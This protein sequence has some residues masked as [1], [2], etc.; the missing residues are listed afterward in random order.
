MMNNHNI[1]VHLDKSIPT[2]MLIEMITCIDIIF[3]CI[4]N[5]CYLLSIEYILRLQRQLPKPTKEK[6]SDH[7]RGIRVLQG[8]DTKL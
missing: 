4:S 6:P 5:Q 2:S 8:K 3:I 1:Q 7:K